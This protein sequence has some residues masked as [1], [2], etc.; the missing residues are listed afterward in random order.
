MSPVHSV[1]FSID[2]FRLLSNAF[3]HITF[4]PRWESQFRTNPEDRRIVSRTFP[5]DSVGSRNITER[6]TW[7]RFASRYFR[8]TP[9]L[10]NENS[11]ST[12]AQPL[13][14]KTFVFF[15]GIVGKQ[16]GA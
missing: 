5:E 15:G 11:P 3:Q 1:F 13:L 6:L 4:V 2:T 12:I 7:E 9:R 14:L 10:M 16:N 8:N